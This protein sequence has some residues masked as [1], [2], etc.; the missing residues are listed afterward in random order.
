VAWNGT[1]SA[2]VAVPDGVYRITVWTADASDNRASVQKFVT[3][4][5]RNAVVTTSMRPTFISP[6]G[7]GKSDTT[8][9]SMRA[10]E[11]LTGTARLINRRTG[12]T[13]RMWRFASATS[14][15]WAWDGRD[16]AG[17][18][19]ADDRYTLRVGGY[20]RAGNPTVSQLTVPVDRT[21]RSVSWSRSSFVP[22]AG[23]TDR[24][25]FAL[26]RPANV[27]LSIYKGSTLVRTVWA[28]SL[29]TGTYGWTW[30]G[31]TSSGALVQPGTYKAVIQATSWI[32]WS[33][34]TRNVTV[35][36]P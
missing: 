16:A 11:A 1:D 20:D 4:D 6:N 27:A 17:R 30:N 22:K 28:R 8:T 29:P 5:N 9:L 18:I 7:D 32:G 10:D 3:V 12:A 14:G 23:Q 25:T 34:F 36:A 35:K 13:V 21:I 24:L 33:S 26:S 15:S 2:N 31:R 19:V